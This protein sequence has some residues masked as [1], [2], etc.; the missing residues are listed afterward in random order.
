VEVEGSELTL[1]SYE[2]QMKEAREAVQAL[3]GRGRSVELIDLRS[4]YPLDEKTL[5]ASVR[6]TGRLLVVHEAPESYGAAAKVMTAAVE[7]AFEY[8][9]APSARLT[10]ADTSIP[11][12]LG[13]HHYL[14]RIA[15]IVA[16][17]E[18]VLWGRPLILPP[19]VGILG[20]GRIHDQPVSRGGA[21]EAVP[22]LPLSLVFDHRA[23]DG[24]YAAGFMRRFMELAERPQ[25][26]L[27]F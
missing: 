13:E 27:L 3:A 17:A 19:Q 18:T 2:A 4:I 21:W 7:G 20:A 14:I 22:H 25:E 5:A 8:L 15:Q 11:L 12:A 24:M 9:Q 1:V 6:K 16:E 26:L 10:G 23:L